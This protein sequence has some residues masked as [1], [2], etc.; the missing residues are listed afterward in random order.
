MWATYRFTIAALLQSN[1]LERILH[2][3]GARPLP[4][5][6][7]EA[8]SRFRD[9]VDELTMLVEWAVDGG[10]A[11][12]RAVVAIVV[13]AIIN[14]FITTVVVAPLI[15]ILGIVVL[16]RRYILRFRRAAR[17]VAGSVAEFVGEMFGAVQAVKV[18]AAEQT[19]IRHFRGL[20]DVRKSAALKDTLFTELMRVVIENTSISA[21]A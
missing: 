2:R 7:S 8:M 4:F 1:L 16:L 15:A 18:A 21:R 12:V 3:P 10:G 14:P 9:D 11:L 20:N 6:S 17:D 13:M 5:S 19:I